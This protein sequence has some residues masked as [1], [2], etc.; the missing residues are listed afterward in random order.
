MCPDFWAS[1]AEDAGAVAGQPF[2]RG[3]Y[4]G[5]LE[6]EMMNSPAW[7]FSQEFGYGRML[8]ERFDQLDFGVF[9]FDESHCNAMSGQGQGPAHPGAERVAINGARGREILDRDGDMIQSSDH[10][11]CS[12]TR[13]HLDDQNM[14]RGPLAPYPRDGIA[15]RFFDCD[16]D[17]IRVAP[18]LP[19]QLIEGLKQS[20][21]DDRVDRD[22]VAGARRNPRRHDVRNSGEIALRGNRQGNCDNPGNR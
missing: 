2:T 1:I 14:D 18:L 10:A 11:D 12:R 13:S 20:V 3:K 17:D 5:D 9:E 21:V 19:G 8:A 7:I 6:T 15:H 4:V 16:G 22:A